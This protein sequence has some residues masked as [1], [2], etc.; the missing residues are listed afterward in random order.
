M[1][2]FEFDIS[3]GN[4][5]SSISRELNGLIN[6]RM[7]TDRAV[8]T[9]QDKW[10]KMLTTSVGDD[11]NAVLSGKTIVKLPFRMKLKYWFNNLLNNINK[12]I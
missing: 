6:D 4:S 3:N 7:M 10:A 9:Q 8:K 1:N 5:P 11:I 12:I 2:N